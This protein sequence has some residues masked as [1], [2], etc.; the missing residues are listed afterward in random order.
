VKI[1]LEFEAEAEKE[2]TEKV[3][4]QKAAMKSWLIGH[5]A[6]KTLKDVAGTQGVN[7]LQRE[8]LEKFEDMLYPGGH[9]PLRNVLFEEY[10]VQ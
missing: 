4:K 3:T 8:M 6:G 1:V 10:V 5:L 7:R 9:G 2:A